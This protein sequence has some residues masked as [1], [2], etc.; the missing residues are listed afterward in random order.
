MAAAKEL[1]TMRRAA[2]LA[3]APA[4]AT[5][6]RAHAATAQP[7]AGSLRNGGM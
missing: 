3:A 7:R 5:A 6:A 4:T 1:I 2:M